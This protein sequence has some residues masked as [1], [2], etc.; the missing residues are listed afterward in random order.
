MK[1]KHPTFHSPVWVWPS[2][3][4]PCWRRA[5]VHLD[6]YVSHLANTGRVPHC[7]LPPLLGRS[8]PHLLRSLQVVWAAAPPPLLPTHDYAYAHWK[9]GDNVVKANAI[10][11]DL[12]K[13]MIYNDRPILP[14]RSFWHL[15]ILHPPRWGCERERCRGRRKRRGGRGRGRHG[16]DSGWGWRRWEE[17][18]DGDFLGLGRI[19]ST[20]GAE[21]HSALVWSAAAA[22]QNCHAAPVEAVSDALVWAALEKRALQDEEQEISMGIDRM[23]VWQ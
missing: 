4:P 20:V 8:S 5:V 16:D 19:F 3:V 21:K 18:R 7:P 12:L 15:A 6:W 22:A 23:H 1:Y 10:E 13:M 2:V 11:N 17:G 9:A 14:D